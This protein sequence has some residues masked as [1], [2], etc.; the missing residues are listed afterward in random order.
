MPMVTMYAVANIDSALWGTRSIGEVKN[1]SAEP[2]V[3][4]NT[5]LTDKGNNLTLSRGSDSEGGVVGVRILT[6]TRGPRGAVRA[7]HT[8]AEVVPLVHGSDLFVDYGSSGKRVA[9]QPETEARRAGKGKE[10]G[11]GGGRKN[12]GLSLRV[13]KFVILAWWVIVNIGLTAS[14]LQWRL[15]LLAAVGFF[16]Q[17]AGLVFFV[18][19]AWFEM[20]LQRSSAL[21]P[22]PP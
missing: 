11:G 15:S 18:V 16:S 19:A 9:E 17:S 21:P 4:T 14:Y 22:S 12:R 7:V 10:G 8:P 6:F 2:I 3:G 20:R 1:A 13:W 5:T